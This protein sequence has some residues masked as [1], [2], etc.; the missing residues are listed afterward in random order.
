MAS[1]NASIVDEWLDDDNLMLIEAWAR[2]GYTKQDIADRIGVHISTLQAWEK[3]YP[4]IKEALRKGREIIDYKVENAL[5]R[6]ALGYTTKEIK[7]VLGRQVKGGQ[8][9]Q[10][11]KEV[12]EKEIA[13]DVTACAIWLNNR[14]PDKWKR[15]RDKIVE[16][17]EQDSNLQITIVRGPKANDDLDSTNQEIMISAKGKGDEQTPAA[18][19][20]SDAIKEEEDDQDYWPD[21]WEDEDDDE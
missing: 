5:L 8:T 17:E 18:S 1:K 19:P 6:R 13:P 14:R 15:N 16:V 11:T 12:V 9:F 20:K 21:D 10:I 7:V 2:D 4:E 3:Q